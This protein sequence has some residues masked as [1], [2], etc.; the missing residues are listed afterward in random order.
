MR[1]SNLFLAA[2]AALVLAASALTQ[3]R[4]TEGPTIEE[5][6]AAL[7][8]GLATLD[9][10]LARVANRAGDDPGQ[11]ELA[12]AGRMTALERAVERLEAD[13]QRAERLA[14]NASR[15]A[16]EAQRNAE[17]AIRDASMRR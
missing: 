16:S 2:G 17:Q 5:R 13:V 15:T 3:E 8:G 7:E 11:S 12:L 6:L 14:D 1:T 9:T 10:R 4:P